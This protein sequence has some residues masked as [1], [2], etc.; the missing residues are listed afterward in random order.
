M[1][2]S[3][4][5]SSQVEFS[6]IHFHLEFQE[7]YRLTLEALLRLRRNLQSAARQIL[8]EEGYVALFESP[9]PADPFA[10]RR[11]QRPGPPFAIIPDTKQEGDYDT[12]ER[13]LLRATFWGKGIRFLSDFAKVLQG[14]GKLG[15]HRGEGL[16]ELVAIDSEDS[17]GNHYPIWQEGKSL[18][19]LSPTINDLRWWLQGFSE[20]ASVVLEFLTPARL[21]SKGRPLFRTDFRG[22]FPFILRRVGSMLY[23]HCGS[24]AIRDP[25]ALLASAA[26]T[27]ELENRLRW[28]D[29]RTLVGPEQTQELGGVVGSI[30]LGG[31]G[32]PEVL[33][34]L[35]IGTLLNVGKGAAFGTGS[36]SLIEHS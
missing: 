14:L 23:A 22:L 21:M 30:R 31:E 36:F 10:L 34:I 26:L 35:R 24:E 16:F 32:L 12:G 25:G 2:D 18:F 33:P 15:L 19:D 1:T 3:F 8:G 5:L 6:L 28:Q 9:L 20:S 4:A 29:W 13:F 17:T 7:P 27:H 11:I